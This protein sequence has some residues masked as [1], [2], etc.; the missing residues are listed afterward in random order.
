MRLSC[1]DACRPVVEF[2][3][4]SSRG[5][6][7]ASL[8]LRSHYVR[9][10]CFRF[11][12]H[13]K[14]WIKAVVAVLSPL[15]QHRKSA[16]L[17]ELPSFLRRR[18]VGFAIEHGAEA[19]TSACLLKLSVGGDCDGAFH[20]L[21]AFGRSNPLGWRHGFGGDPFRGQE[22]Q[23]WKALVVAAKFLQ[24]CPRHSDGV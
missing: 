11:D 20:L 7:V 3:L 16:M 12:G 1:D 23:Q 4:R 19:S 6:W 15:L 8:A 5:D 21:T 17:C 10:A 22:V 24:C 18:G 9:R 14:Q 13:L 2:L